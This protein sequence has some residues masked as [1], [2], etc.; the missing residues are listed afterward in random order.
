MFDHKLTVEE[1]TRISSNLSNMETLNIEKES[2]EL[3][4]SYL[5]ISDDSYCKKCDHKL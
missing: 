1:N 4:E 3:K 5:V 2:I